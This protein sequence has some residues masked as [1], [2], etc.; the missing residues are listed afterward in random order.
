M[1]H[2]ERVVSTVKGKQVDRVPADY[3]GTPEATKKYI[4]QLNL[5]NEFELIQ[6]LDTDVIRAVA[7]P[8][9]VKFSRE[10]SFMKNVQ[11]IQEVR[12]LSQDIPPLDDLIDNTP[13][14]ET[15]KAHPDYAIMTYGPGSIFLGANSFFGYET[16]LMHHATRPDLIMELI[17]CSVEYAFAVIDKLYRDVGDAVDIVSLEDDFGTQTSLYISYEMFLKFYKPAFSKVISHLKKYGYL[18][19]FHSCGAVFQLID[20]FIE[21]GVD[22]LDPVQVSAKGMDIETLAMKYK[23]KICFHGGT[24]TQ[25]LL[26]YGTPDE[27]KKQVRKII[28]LFEGT[29]I[30]VCPSQNFLPD[31]PIENLLAMYQTPRNF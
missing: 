28:C 23:D 31:I 15:R 8:G 20:D 9:K 3:Y 22:I 12:K 24:D 29:R 5:R 30:F 13:I 18:V 17:N 1:T 11:T 16:S 10:N 14:I 27:V 4:D 21:M 6:F 19:Q 26:P 25:K 7:G 2:R